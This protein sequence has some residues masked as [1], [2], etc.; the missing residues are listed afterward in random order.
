MN[1]DDVDFGGT[2]VEFAYKPSG[3][4]SAIGIALMVG[5]G[6]LAA[7]ASGAIIHFVG[8]AA[9][10]ALSY[11]GTLW[12]LAG[13]FLMFTVIPGLAG[14]GLGWV[15]SKAAILGK[16]RSQKTAAVI[17]VVCSFAAIGVY[18]VLRQ[19]R[20][21]EEAFDSAIDIMKVGFALACMVVGAAVSAAGGIAEKPF[22][23]SCQSYMNKRKSKKLPR[24][25][26]AVAIDLC[27]SGRLGELAKYY[28]GSDVGGDHYAVVEYFY[29]DK[30][31]SVGFLNVRAYCVTTKTYWGQAT[32]STG[33]RLVFSIPLSKDEIGF[34]VPRV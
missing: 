26:Q 16:S 18:G 7:P 11:G 3:K 5:F 9:V 25:E 1:E 8:E 2:T 15:V 22:C 34:L 10:S 4:G 21:G 31:M 6:G 32:T 29:C 23:E 19:N 24:T 28:L 30:C 33:D 13:I 17:A 12:G 14:A 20:Y 27:K